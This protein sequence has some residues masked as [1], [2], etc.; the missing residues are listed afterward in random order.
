MDSD[1]ASWRLS[2]GLFYGK[3]YGIVKKSFTGKISFRF[4]Y[5]MQFFHSLKN[6]FLFHSL[7]I[8]N[9]I[10]NIEIAILV[11][12]LIILSGDVKTNPGPDDLRNH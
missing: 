8:Y 6:S 5:L 12:L 3:A 4:I 2:I 10:N 1:V 11:W 7:A 9:S